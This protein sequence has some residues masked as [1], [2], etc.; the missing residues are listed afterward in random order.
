VVLEGNE[1]HYL[2]PNTFSGLPNLQRLYLRYNPDLQIP[3]DRIFINS[4]SSTHLAISGC[5]VSSVSVETFANV[6]A[7]EWLDLSNNSLNTVD[8]N[9]LRALPKLSTL[10]LDG[11][12]LQ[13]D[14]QLQEV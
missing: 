10:Y 7:L 13:C 2:H 5:N 8:I 3:T 12:P 6:S 9:I 14:C 11:N 1:L 4:S